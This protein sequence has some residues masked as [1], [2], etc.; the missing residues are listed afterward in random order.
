MAVAFIDYCQAQYPG[1][2]V[3]NLSSV[4]DESDFA[5]IFMV[6]VRRINLMLS[7]MQE[8]GYVNLFT[9]VPPYGIALLQTDPI[10]LL[11]KMYV[12]EEPD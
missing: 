8:I 11:E 7:R 6:G 3:I 10:P 12:N 5:K 2:S 1:A 9:S 4:L